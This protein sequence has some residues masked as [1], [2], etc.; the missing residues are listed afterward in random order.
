[1]KFQPLRILMLAISAFAVC[2]SAATPTIGVATSMGALT[3]N[4]A[5]IT[6]NANI[7]DGA[8]VSTDKAPTQI[9][10]RNGSNLTLGTNS[11]ANIYSDR[12]ILLQGGVRVDGMS[13]YNVEASGFR[14]QPDE[15][16]TTAIVRYD[17]ANVQV[18]A[19]AGAV[20][21]FN[22]KGALITRV[23]AGTAASFTPRQQ[24]QQSGSGA[25]TG[26]TVTNK[27]LWIALGTVAAAFLAAGLAG[28]ALA[29]SGSAPPQSFH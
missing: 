28:A 6:G 13:K 26:E 27:Y 29:E 23:G 21:V 20:K 12:V 7:F 5:R 11:A 10:L 16:N 17:T 19:M 9:L 15:N 2:A 4:N 25:S 22:V 24:G 18:G 8:Q 3:V 14:I 1:M